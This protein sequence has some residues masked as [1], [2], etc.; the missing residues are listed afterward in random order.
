MYGNRN[1]FSEAFFR[2]V[3]I[4]R[5]LLMPWR[6]TSGTGDTAPHILDF[7]TRLVVSFTFRSLSPMN[8]F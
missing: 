7:D 6:H 2:R 8:E 3:N 5:L 1:V 4:K